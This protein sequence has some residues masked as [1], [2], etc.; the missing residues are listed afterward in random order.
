MLPCQDSRCRETGICVHVAPQ[1]D[2]IFNRQRGRR[3]P[4]DIY[5][6]GRKLQRTD[7]P[8]VIDGRKMYGVKS[9]RRRKI[10]V[11]TPEPGH[12]DGTHGN[13]SCG[14]IYLMPMVICCHSARAFLIKLEKKYAQ[15]VFRLCAIPCKSR[16]RT[17]K[18]ERY[19][20]KEASL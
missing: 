9:A 7:C 4:G 3:L 19:L 2:A 1:T 6:E 10:Y 18:T 17:I 14:L 8:S 15:S 16:V 11:T 20:F 13:V 12:A 5:T